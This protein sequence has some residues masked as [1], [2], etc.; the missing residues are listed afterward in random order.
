MNTNEL[1]FMLKLL[2]YPSYRGNW[3]L[4]RDKEKTKVCQELERREYVDYSREIVSA[5]ILPAGKALLQIQTSQL[6]ITAEELKVLEK[7]AK[8]GK[9]IVTSEIKI[10]K[11]KS[12]QKEVILKTLGERGLIK[13]ELKIKKNQAEVWLTD[14]GLEFLRSEYIPNKT[15]N[16]AISLELLGNYIRFLR[17]NVIPT[18]PS[19]A[20]PVV[21]KITDRKIT[22]EEILQTIKNLDRELGTENYLPIFHLR[23]K[24]QPPLLR[25]E[26]DQALYRLQKSDKIDFSSL[27]EVTAYTPEQIDAGI[28]QN[29]GGQLF[30]IMVN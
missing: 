16:P 4:F 9:K 17:K 5:Q 11:L 6:P 8:A 27:Q 24:L 29:I 22:D 15:Y 2:G 26:V 19:G 28:P 13:T 12:D 30:F 23:E 14:R 18:D 3:S 1:K 10:T 25:D 7:I 20:K 21:D